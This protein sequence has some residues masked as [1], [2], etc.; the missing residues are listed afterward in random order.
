MIEV[1]AIRDTSGL[2]C[3]GAT[4]MNGWTDIDWNGQQ[5]NID[6]LNKADGFNKTTQS[7]FSPPPIS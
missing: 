6:M 3:Q 2:V 4:R 1:K 7:C 5:I